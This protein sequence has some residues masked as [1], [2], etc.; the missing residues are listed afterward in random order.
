V[1][2]RPR[3]D[4]R[5]VA[6]PPNRTGDPAREWDGQRFVRHVARGASSL[7]WRLPGWTYRESGVADAT[8]GLAGVRVARPDHG[9]ATDG[10]GDGWVAHDT[11]FAQL[12]VLRG[13]VT[14]EADDGRTELLVDG[15]A[16]AIPGGRRYRLTEP[17]V[18]CELLDVTLP[19][20]V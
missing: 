11:E 1:P 14:F 15:S 3:D 6:P 7:A 16:V 8:G 19:A 10:D 9:A 2:G 4:R 17:S 18:D 12:V 13:S 5:L 20:R